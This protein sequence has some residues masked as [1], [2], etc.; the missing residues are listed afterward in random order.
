MTS[1]E[2]VRRMLG[3]S[4]I[5]A[6][7]AVRQR[8]RYGRETL[9]GNRGRM[10]IYD[11]R[12]QDI[13]EYGLPGG[14]LF[15]GYYDLQQVDS[16][17]WR[18][19]AHAVP[20][21]AD[22]ARNA[23]EIAWVD[24]RDGSIHTITATRA[25]CWQQGARLRWNP[26][27]KETVLLN[28]V[29]RGQYR[30]EAWSL[31][32]KKLYDFPLAFYDLSGDVETGIGL[33]FS[34]LQRLRPGYGY[35]VLPD[36][37]SGLGAPRNDGVF[38]T[39]LKNGDT[40][41]AFS[42]MEL[43]ESSRAPANAQHYVNHVSVS[44]GGKRFIFFHLWTPG[45]FSQWDMRLYT[46]DMDGGG[47]RCVESESVASHYAW[48]DDDTLLYTTCGG[49]KGRPSRYILANVADG[50]RR[51]LSSEHLQ[52]DGHPSFLPEGNAF[53]SDTYPQARCMQRLF[54]IGAD[55]EGYRPLMDIY[56][57]PLKYGE[58]RCDLH[59][60][61]TPDGRI[62]TI[63]NTRNGTRSILIARRAG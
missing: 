24:A 29:V 42:L 45:A 13:R 12:L 32:G 23:A 48:R 14:H 16:E 11:E 35:P 57:D 43:A 8:L 58:K 63:D 31:S 15:F 1:R 17:G 46:A 59:P 3:P 6:A 44:P 38:L 21:H 10:V 37:T 51:V 4:G 36:A 18:L 9:G 30:T 2:A 27:E 5:A 20:I 50:T 47:L 28:N 41:L 33:N 49:S 19:L 61:V 55:G 62:L 26:L 40:R 22:P 52:E 53:L 7:N 56:A 54:E 60:R 34:R 39:S 25:W